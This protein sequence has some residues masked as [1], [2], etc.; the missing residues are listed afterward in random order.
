MSTLYYPPLLFA[1]GFFSFGRMKYEGEGRERLDCLFRCTTMSCAFGLR[2]T[3]MTIFWT[4]WKV[5]LLGIFPILWILRAYT[6]LRNY[7][8]GIL[9]QCWRFHKRW[10][11]VKIRNKLFEEPS[12]PYTEAGVDGFFYLGLY[13]KLSMAQHLNHCIRIHFQALCANSAFFTLFCPQ[14]K[15]FLYIANRMSRLQKFI[16]NL[17]TTN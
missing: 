9:R 3:R 15:I 5:S 8:F 11:T 12:T 16:K 6:D 7:R 10:L 4:A 13:D 17:Y 14:T 2:L 1:R